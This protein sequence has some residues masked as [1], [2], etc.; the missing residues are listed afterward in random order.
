[1]SRVSYYL[2]E[3]GGGFCSDVTFEPLLRRDVTQAIDRLEDIRLFHLKIRASYAQ[4]VAR[5]NR[6]LGAAFEAAAEA[7]E[8]EE[9][10]IILRPR[11]YSGESLA[12]R[13]LGVA[14]RL[15]RR[16]DLRTEASKFE[17]RGLDEESARVETVDILRDQLIA[18]RQIIQQSV[19]GRALDR[20][21]AYAAITSAYEDMREELAAAAA[22]AP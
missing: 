8:A 2:A 9:L 17:I 15:A 19:R 21:S 10:E 20:N 11:R 16:G 22:I 6:S 18:R 3:K 7:G 4:V 14:R 1:M 13:L 5:A 12:G